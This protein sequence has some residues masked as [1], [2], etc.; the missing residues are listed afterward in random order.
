MKMVEGSKAYVKEAINLA[1]IR[2]KIMQC[3]HC[4]HP[5]LNGY[6]C[7]YCGSDQPTYYGQEESWIES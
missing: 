5:T 6:H 1:L 4:G 3:Q 2:V 7:P